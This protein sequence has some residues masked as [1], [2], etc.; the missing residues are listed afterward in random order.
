MTLHY[1]DSTPSNL[2]HPAN[3]NQW[4]NLQLHHTAGPRLATLTSYWGI[5]DLVLLCWTTSQQLYSGYCYKPTHYS[6]STDRVLSSTFPATHHNMNPRCHPLLRHFVIS[7][8]LQYSR[9]YP[10]PLIPISNL[11]KPKIHSFNT[12][13]YYIQASLRTQHV[14]NSESQTLRSLVFT[15]PP[16]NS[17][18][19]DHNSQR[20][21]WPYGCVQKTQG[22][23]Q[24]TI[25]LHFQK[26]PT[27]VPL[28][29]ACPHSVKIP[30]KFGA[31]NNLT[32]PFHNLP[33]IMY[34][35]WLLCLCKNKGFMGGIWL[36]Q[37]T[38]LCLTLGADPVHFHQMFWRGGKREIHGMPDLL[39]IQTILGA[40][41][42]SPFFLFFWHVA[43]LWLS[44]I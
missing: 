26:S 15:W 14:S 34:Y 44:H 17:S 32:C 29:F 6:F 39:G 5:S 11:L 27:R 8:T 9:P 28:E 42:C 3:S 21:L 4:W 12:A 20:L 25:D 23:K 30:R 31:A 36:W 43:V 1:S 10:K 2:W 7:T 22:W 16:P 41:V 13:V 38:K 18:Q 35:P 37:D 24:P 33:D 40:N 19:H